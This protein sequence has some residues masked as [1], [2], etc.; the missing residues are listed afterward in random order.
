M[1][2]HEI[3]FI[4]PSLAG[5]WRAVCSCGKYTGKAYWTQTRATTVW[6]AHVRVKTKMEQQQGQVQA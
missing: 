4:G 2:T 6:K 5:R 1:T 3:G